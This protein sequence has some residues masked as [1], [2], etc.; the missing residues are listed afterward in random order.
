MVITLD[1]VRQN[2]LVV[3]HDY[4]SALHGDL[5]LTVGL[6]IITVVVRN[7]GLANLKDMI[8]VYV[9]DEDKDGMRIMV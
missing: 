4:T 3:G 1:F 8:L 2:V 9:K 6:G 7:L 5:V